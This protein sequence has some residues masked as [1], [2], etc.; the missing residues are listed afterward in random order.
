MSSSLDESNLCRESKNLK[1]KRWRRIREKLLSYSQTEELQK[2]SA[3]I[4]FDLK[5]WPV[6][7]VSGQQRDDLISN[8]LGLQ[9]IAVTILH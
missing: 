8:A 7:A 9:E 6:I 3:V 2:N 5:D 1:K 4:S